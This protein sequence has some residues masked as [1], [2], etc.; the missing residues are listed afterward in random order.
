MAAS[1][2]AASPKT[3]KVSIPR[4]AQ[5]DAGIVNLRLPAADHQLAVQSVVCGPCTLIVCLLR[6]LHPATRGPST[7]GRR[8]LAEDARGH[9][10]DYHECG[11]GV[12]ACLGK[13]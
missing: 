11:G 8:M 12:F 2:D 6:I 3:A 4:E 7:V 13:L 10:A 5:K 1:G 9:R